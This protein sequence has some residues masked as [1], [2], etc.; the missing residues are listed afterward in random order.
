MATIRI[1]HASDLHIAENKKVVSPADAFTDLR[2][3]GQMGLRSLSLLAMRALRMFLKKSAA[4]SYDSDLLEALAELI[5]EHAKKKLDEDEKLVEEDGPDKLD[6]VVFTG[7]LATTG[8]PADIDMVYDFLKAKFDPRYLHQSVNKAATLSAVKIPVWYFPGNHDRFTPTRALTRIKLFPFPKFYEPGATTYDGKFWDFSTDPVRVLGDAPA[9][10]A[11]GGKLR[12]VMIAADFNLRQFGDHK[13][14]F[15]WL[16]QGRVYDDILTSLVEKTRQ[17]NA[18]HKE[19]GADVLCVL[20]AIHFPPSFPHI[21]K[22][23]RLLFEEALLARANECEVKA[24]LAGHTHEQ[25]R[26]RKPGMNA[27]VLCCGTTTQYVPVPP[28]RT[29]SEGNR[30]QIITVTAESTDDIQIGV[31]N[32]KYKSPLL[33]GV[34]RA[35]YYKV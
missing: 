18:K 28:R 2:D 34:F 32:Y 9:D 15:G 1:L 30:F 35:S 29:P 10:L 8:L 7:D 20:W 12:V 4:S 31:E 6:A 14:V 22:S 19:S 5:Y 23:S 24:I 17:E 33:D 16:A 13:G 21:G 3:S 26:Y 25:V 11:G 27:D